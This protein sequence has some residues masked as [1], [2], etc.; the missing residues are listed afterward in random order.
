MYS[1]HPILEDILESPT[2]TNAEAKRPKCPSRSRDREVL[3]KEKCVSGKEKGA[4]ES[5]KVK[6]FGTI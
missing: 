6:Y 3:G 5:E 4:T 2:E 1:F